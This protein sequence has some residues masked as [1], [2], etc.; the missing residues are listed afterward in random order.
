M[1]SKV[2]TNPRLILVSKPSQS[3]LATDS[4]SQKLRI[5]KLVWIVCLNLLAIAAGV[6]VLYKTRIVFGWILIA[7]FLALTLNLIIEWLQGKG[8]KRWVALSSVFAA[9]VIGIAGLMA[10]VVPVL[11]EQGKS[12]FESA[13]AMLEQIESS[14]SVH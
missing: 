12:F 7:L 11:I 1:S 6:Y 10:T 13:P 5:V 2:P 8:W 4:K 9:I 3:P 14:K